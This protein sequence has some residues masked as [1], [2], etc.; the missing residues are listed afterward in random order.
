MTLK[1]WTVSGAPSPWR[2]ALGLAFKGVTYETIMLS[3]SKQEHKSEPYIKLNPRGTIPTLQTGD[4]TLRDSVAI[5]AWLDRE[6]PE[7]PLFGQTPT[8]A[9]AI[10][11]NTMEILQYLPP[12]AH[13]VLSPILQKGVT[14]AD[15]ALQTA[16]STLKQELQVLET[17][18]AN[19][20]YL[21]GK[22]PGAAD[23]VTFPHL[24]LIQRAIDTK[25]TIMQAISMHDMQT[26]APEGQKWLTRIESLEHVAE[27]FPPHWT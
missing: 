2:V 22:N 5:L 18:L 7:K 11:Q 15:D 25:P 10:W 24:R 21:S 16:A 20:P 3:A 12:A 19:Q 14:Q 9:G 17:I 4:L 26:F 8:E 6:Y 27:T 23:A 1:F 13:D